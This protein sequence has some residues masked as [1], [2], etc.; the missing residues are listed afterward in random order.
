MRNKIIALMQDLYY[1]GAR[2]RALLIEIG[3]RP[4]QIPD[5][6]AAETFWP[7]VVIRL[8]TGIVVD[9]IRLLVAVAARDHP[10]NEQA[11]ALLAEI[12]GPAKSVRVLCFFADPLRGSKIRIDREARLLN[13]LAQMGGFTLQTR[14][15]VRVNDIIQSIL[16]EKPSILHFAGHGAQDGRLVFEDDK[17]APDGVGP[18]ALAE[19]ISASAR[20]VLDCVVLNSCYTASNAEPFGRATRVVA[21]SV[22]ALDDDCALAFARGFYTGIGAG[23]TA[24]E[25][26]RTGRAQMSLSHCDTSGLHMVSFSG[27]AS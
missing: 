13:E 21:G 7:E 19:A 16:N 22:S 25:A 14:H 5:F 12:R 11:S 6:R 2:A 9:G 18:D 27:A 24:A 8:E 23:Q 26:Y 1:D 17:G 3:C 10:G 20:G 4:A 15:A